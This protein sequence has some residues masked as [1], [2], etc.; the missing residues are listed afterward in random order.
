MIV[1]ANEVLPVILYILGAILLVALIVL[2]VKLTIT[3]HKIDKVVDNITEKVTALD[4]VFSVVNAVSNKFT[5]ITDKVVEI[6]YSL[7]ERI[8]KRKEEWKMSK[9]G[10][11]KFALGAG[12]GA[13]LALLFAPKK[14]SDLRRDIKRKFDEFMTDVD[15][16][17]VEDIKE[18][19]TEK[20]E[21]IK[22]EL[23]D[24]DKEKVE[25]IAK[26]KAKELQ[27][28]AEDLVDLAK[29]KGTPVLEGIAEDLKHKVICVCTEVINKLERGE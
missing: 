28:K 8:T 26:K 29:E 19:F 17:E 3:I 24:L 12:I 2:T 15:K 22:K 4:G 9:N 16:I 6:I 25:K 23:D 1:T 11:G 14:G 13:G 27:R 5:F 20:V 21:D 18:S 7:I 10:F